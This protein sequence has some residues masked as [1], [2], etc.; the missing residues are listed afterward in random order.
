MP[1]VIELRLRPTAP[2]PA[3]FA[4]TARQLHGLAC[5]LFDGANHRDQS[6]PWSVWPLRRSQDTSDNGGWLLR[7]AWLLDGFP[8][9]VLASCGTV[10]LGPVECAVTEVAFRP[11]SHHELADVPAADG[12]RLQFLSPAYFA[13]NGQHVTD[14][15]VRLIAGS[16]RRRWNASL[17]A[18]SDLEIDADLWR[19]I[20][21][22]LHLTGNGL[23]VQSQDTGYRTGDRWQQR[24][25]LVGTATL[26]LEQEAPP[27]ARHAFASLARFAEYSGTGAQTTHA[28]GATKTT[29]LYP[30]RTGG[31]VPRDSG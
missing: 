25:G 11:I 4:P 24:E 14:P 1:A 3:N 12:V 31:Q 18:G 5:A 9:T 15:D 26:R 6:K 20:H 23:T 22:A 17:P 28:F 21:L 30:A 2:L 7:G 16:W 8:Q 13:Q 29:L 10:G 19:D 27:D